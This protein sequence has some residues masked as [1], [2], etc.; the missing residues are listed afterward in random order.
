MCRNF[1]GPSGVNSEASNKG[2][3]TALLLASR[4][5]RNQDFGYAIIGG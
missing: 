2:I 4:N 3:G 5:M 1:F